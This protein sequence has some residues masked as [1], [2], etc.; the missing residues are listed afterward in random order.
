MP[1]DAE[2]YTQGLVWHDGH[3]YE[4]AGQYGQSTLRRVDLATGRSLVLAGS[5]ARDL[6]GEGL[7]R[8]EGRLIQLTWREGTALVWDREKL[9]EL[10]RLPY[11]GEGWGLCFDG[12]PSGDERRQ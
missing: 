7:A 2:A 11:A 10:D 3:L 5:V 8:V 12:R 1:H 9:T 4:S 6:F